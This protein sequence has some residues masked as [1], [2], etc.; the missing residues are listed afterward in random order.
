MIVVT[1]ASGHLGRLVLAGLRERLPANEIIATTRTPDAAA[2]LRVQVR[3]A[4]FDEPATLPAAYAGADT[5]VL[6]SSNDVRRRAAQH[7]AAIDAAGSAGV[8][9]I[10]STRGLHARHAPL[11][12]PP[13][14]RATEAAIA[15]PRPHH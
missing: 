13:D 6:I 1:G 5:L 10:G 2:D 9:S 14:H 8:R 3:H 12:I 4:D 7:K 15:R 11:I